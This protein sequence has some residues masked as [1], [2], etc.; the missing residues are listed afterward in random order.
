[1]KMEIQLIV[2]TFALSLFLVSYVRAQSEAFDVTKYGAAPN[3][4]ITN[5]RSN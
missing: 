3:E 4:D 2:T 1:M 5:V